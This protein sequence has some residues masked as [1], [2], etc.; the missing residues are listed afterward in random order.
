VSRVRV[1]VVGAGNIAQEHLKVLTGQPLAEVV[2]LCDRDPKTLAETG[3][4]FGIAER[5]GDPQAV[6]RRDDL[7]A[8]Y[9]L[10]SVLA[11]AEVATPFIGA[12][13]PVFLEKPPGIASAETARL[14]E[15]QQ[16]RG[17]IAVVG[18]NRRFYAA[19]LAL[20]ER[21]QAGGSP[22]SVTVEAHEDLA[23]VSRQKF[24]PLVLRRWAYANGIHALDLLRFFGGEVTE[25]HAFR[26]AFEH[27]FPDCLTAHLRFASGGH[28]RA[29]VDWVAPGRHRF[30]VRAAGVCATSSPG[31]G[32][33]TLTMRGRP[34]EGLEPDADDRRF[35]PGFWKE[36][37]AF[38][39]GV[40]RGQ[41]PPFPSASLADAH[42][43]MVM[44]DQICGFPPDRGHE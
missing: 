9:V 42:R 14:A 2:L 33:V 11:V 22:L 29:A 8:V 44:I 19:H 36:T 26:D 18:L 30:E 43:T 41:Q 10:V 23:R 5:V 17:T 6:L 16:R 27:D 13:L 25:V 1:A 12:G 7:D 28:G 40:R 3:A 24:P 15:L 37:E 32:A 34:E 39:Q 31:F 21:F 35:K 4:R 20:R 38:L